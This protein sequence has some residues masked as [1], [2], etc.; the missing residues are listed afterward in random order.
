MRNPFFKDLNQEEICHAV[1][2][3]DT[4]GFSP[5]YFSRTEGEVYLAGLNSTMITLPETAQDVKASPEAIQK[6]KDCA[7]AMMGKVDEKEVEILRES[8]VCAMSRNPFLQWNHSKL[9]DRCLLFPMCSV[10]DL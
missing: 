4:L 6:L 10:S 7:A 5:E 9:L 8:L 1:F 3:T 2:A